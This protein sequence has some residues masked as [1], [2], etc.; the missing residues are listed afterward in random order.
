MLEPVYEP[1]AAATLDE[2]E[3]DDNRWEL[4]NAIC[5]AIDLVCER[6][7]STWARLRTNRLRGGRLVHEVA[8]QSAD[9]WIL[10]WS[11]REGEALIAYVGPRPRLR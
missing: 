9:N 11:P 7:D 1:D 2:I 4:W 8:I 10:L 3:K 5:D 6:P